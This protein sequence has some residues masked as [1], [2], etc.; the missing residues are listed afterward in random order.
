MRLMRIAAALLVV[1][2]VGVTAQSTPAGQW[3]AV[4]AHPGDPGN[5]KM[6]TEV[7]LDLKVDGTRLTGTADMPTWPGLAPIADG[8]TDGDQF[9][10]TWTGLIPANAN[11]RV[12]YPSMT[13]VGTVEGDSM[14]LTM[15][16][17]DVKREMTGKRLPLR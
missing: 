11:G 17:G 5:P 15:T 7:L 4:F 16:E 10:F 8:K 3:R 14:Q 13:F 9:S 6:F 12:V 1:L 2:A